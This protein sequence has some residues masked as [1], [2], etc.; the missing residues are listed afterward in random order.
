[1]R[2]AMAVI[3]TSGYTG[4]ESLALGLLDGSTTF[5]G[6]PYSVAEPTQRVREALDAR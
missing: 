4:D 5:L 1:M 3:Y 6:K 2:P